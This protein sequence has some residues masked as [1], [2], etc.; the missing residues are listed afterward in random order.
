MTH[1]GIAYPVRVTGRYD[2]DPSRW[3]WLI[4]VVLV[5]PHAIV[6]VGLWT[7]AFFA[8]L[9]AFGTDRHPPFRLDQGGTETFAPVQPI[10]PQP[11]GMP[12][13]PGPATA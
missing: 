10:A 11:T 3:L 13:T 4:L 9:G 8:T 2:H 6:L 12:S 5:I 1:T 7:G